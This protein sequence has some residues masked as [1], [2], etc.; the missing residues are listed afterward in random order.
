MDM[1]HAILPIYTF[2]HICIYAQIHTSLNTY[3]VRGVAWPKKVR[4]QTL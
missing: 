1:L 4:R 3:N 2:A